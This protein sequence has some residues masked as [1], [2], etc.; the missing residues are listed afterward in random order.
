[1][2]TFA[3]GF[4]IGS[5]AEQLMVKPRNIAMKI[6][7]FVISYSPYESG[8]HLGKKTCESLAVLYVGQTI[9]SSR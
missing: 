2:L 3:A 7:D 4:I 8:Q 6:V 5:A 1:L 9:D